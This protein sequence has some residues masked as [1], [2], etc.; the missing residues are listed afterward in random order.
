MFNAEVGKYGKHFS[1]VS[2][3]LRRVSTLFTALTAVIN[4]FF[5]RDKVGPVSKHAAVI[6]TTPRTENGLFD[7]GQRNDGPPG[8]QQI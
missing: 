7:A 8:W 6:A 4:Y 3:T 1:P 5:P 2:F